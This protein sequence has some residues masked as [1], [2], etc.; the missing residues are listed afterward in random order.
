MHPNTSKV[1]P[2]T[3]KLIPHTLVLAV[4]FGAILLSS[5]K[6]FLELTPGAQISTSNFYNKKADFENAV[7]GVYATLRGL[8]ST[9]NSLYM[10]ELATDNA[11]ISWSSPTTDEMQFDQNALTP[12]NQQV[13]SIWNTC[14]YT[15][16]Q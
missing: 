2:H 10:S 7:V 3:S 16:A 13:R 5:C 4:I 15:V 9:S 14:L 1:S 8:Y 12:T 11:E 6:K